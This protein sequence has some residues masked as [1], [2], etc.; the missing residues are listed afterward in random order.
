[1]SGVERR[2]LVKIFGG[3]KLGGGVSFLVCMG[4]RGEEGRRGGGD[5]REGGYGFRGEGDL[6]EMAG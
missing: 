6:F 1:M 5:V 3:G 4:G 2:A